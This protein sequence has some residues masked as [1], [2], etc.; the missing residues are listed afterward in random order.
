MPTLLYFSLHKS[1]K[2]HSDQFWRWINREG[3][4]YAEHS[5]FT[6]A[7]APKEFNHAA[8]LSLYLNQYE[9]NLQSLHIIIDFGSIT[10]NQ[11]SYIRD[12]IVEF[13][14]TQFLFD[15][16]YC[17]KT[18]ALDFLFPEDELKEDQIKQWKGILDEINTDLFEIDYNKPGNT[19]NP[20]VLFSQVINGFDNTF[21]ASNLR[22]AIKYWKYLILKVGKRNYQKLQES[23]SKHIA[24][25][26]EEEV[27]QNIF[28]SY[29]LYTNGFRVFPITTRR[30]LE[31]CNQNLFEIVPHDIHSSKLNGIVIRDYDLQFEDEDG[32][33]IDAIRGYRYC[34]QDEIKE[35][36]SFKENEKKFFK[37]YHIGWNYLMVKYHRNPNRYWSNIAIRLPLYFITKGP[38]PTISEVVHPSKCS[39]VE[40][41]EADC[42]ITNKQGKKEIQTIKTK[43]K[44]PGFEKPVCGLYTPFFAI[45]EIKKRYDATR[46][47]IKEDGE[48]IYA[49]R[50]SRKDH[51][52]ST[53]LDI[54]D[55]ANRM[56]RRAEKYYESKLYILAALVAGE[57]LEVLNGFHHRLTVKAYYIQ[58]IAENAIAMD[59]VGGNEEYLA[60]DTRQRVEKIN[61]DI[62]RIFF[63]YDEKNK[64]YVL[65]QIYSTCR[66]FCK[67]HKHF[68]SEEI[69]ISALGHLLEGYTIPKLIKILLNK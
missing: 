7:E 15:K 31:I 60:K 64:T 33:K 11:A 13:P 17:H 54:Y 35:G 34:E 47:Q 2:K 37:D 18:S 66:E 38:N 43:I 12:A 55:L 6:P 27:R 52:H 8:D 16:H 5:I 65:N 24:I 25:C 26:V 51:D 50:T 49:I 68:E 10:K 61:E 3:I 22:Y 46:Y 48:K 21:D 32:A 67:E 9:G 40:F 69:F 44:L 59:V 36:S 30:E 23:R 28:T 63:K 53:P 1:Q 19:Q 39:N 14:E 58:A 41:E 4:K 42:E 29:A 56:I 20:S 45:T 62:D 57:A